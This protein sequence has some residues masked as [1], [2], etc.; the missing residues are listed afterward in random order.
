M[1]P[2]ISQ[3]GQ[4]TTRTTHSTSATAGHPTEEQIRR[5]AYEIYIA[6]GGSGG[7]PDSDWRQAEQELRG[8]MTL[9]GKS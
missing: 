9:L 2:R 8:R 3:T 7:N 1:P 5:R 4:R 6:R